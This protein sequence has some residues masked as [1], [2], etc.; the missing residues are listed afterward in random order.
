MEQVHGNLLRTTNTKEASSIHPD[1]SLKKAGGSNNV[2]AL[3]LEHAL[4]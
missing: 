2:P 4:D 3:L 1:E